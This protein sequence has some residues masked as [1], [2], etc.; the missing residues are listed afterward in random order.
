MIPVQE[1][2]QNEVIGSHFQIENSS[3]NKLETAIRESKTKQ[4]KEHDDK[5]VYRT[6]PKLLAA[7]LPELPNKKE[8]SLNA[9]DLLLEKEKNHNKTESWNKLDKTVKIQKLH[10]FAET[11]VHNHGLP[12]KEVKHLKA[13]FLECLEKNKLSKTKDL[14]YDKEQSA[15]ISIP[16]LQFNA[17]THN[18]T[19]RNM[20][21]KHVSTLRSLTP[22]MHSTK[23]EL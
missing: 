14:V 7:T 20:D 1:G 4:K 13:F 6:S 11:Y 23:A 3:L 9:M 2:V 10:A 8:M 19:L 12:I 17:T 16:S 22:K 21:P 18:F 5:M 15:I